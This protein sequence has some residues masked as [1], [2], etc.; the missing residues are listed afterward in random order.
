[1]LTSPPLNEEEKDIFS[2]KAQAREELSS[3][4]SSVYKD[5]IADGKLSEQ[6]LNALIETF[7]RIP[8]I[9]S[10]MTEEICSDT[11]P[12][13]AYCCAL[14]KSNLAYPYL[15]LRDAG[16][17]ISKVFSAGTP[18]GYISKGNY[19]L[20]IGK[21]EAFTDSPIWLYLFGLAGEVGQIEELE[22][23]PVDFPSIDSDLLEKSEVLKA[24]FNRLHELLINPRSAT[25]RGNVDAV[26]AARNAVDFVVLEH[27]YNLLEYKKLAYAGHALAHG[28]RKVVTPSVK[29]T[30]KTSAYVGFKLS[31]ILIDHLNLRTSTIH[32]ERVPMVNFVL[33]L[34]RDIAE[35]VQWTIL[36]KSFIEKPSETLKRGIRQGPQIRKK[37]STKKNFYVPFS[38]VKSAECTSYPT[39]VRKECADAGVLI[40]NFVDSVNNLSIPD[41]EKDLEH[42]QQ[43]LAAMYAFSDRLRREWR[44]RQHVPMAGVI[45]AFVNEFILKN[46]DGKL[47]HRR[48]DAKSVT[49]AVD[50]SPFHVFSD[51]KQE[52]ASAAATLKDLMDK[53]AQRRGKP[54]R[55]V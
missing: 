21:R 33:G 17:G 20:P 39:G 48:V 14:S 12:A 23:I 11:K 13:E 8:G 34:L 10:E 49:D 46:D 51:N 9:T 52:V 54:L 41:L 6:E 4:I 35:K 36:P 27:A 47:Y 38:Y 19:K 2:S 53:K 37:N 5:E 42:C 16:K 28:R 24:V 43:T 3:T 40:M 30:A 29:G 1:M 22:D 44:T 25:I 31:E 18:W 7:L 15:T 55:S 50:K 45:T 26:S 32:K